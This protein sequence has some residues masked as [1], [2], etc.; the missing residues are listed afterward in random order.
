MT[1][2]R[3]RTKKKAPA[4]RKKKAARRSRRPPR[5]DP[6][7]QRM[8][9]AIE[10]WEAYTRLRSY[11]RVADELGVSVW[12]VQRVLNEDKGRLEELHQQQLEERVADF[13]AIGRRALTRLADTL[14]LLDGNIR[15][16]RAAAAEGRVTRV[17]D[18]D[19]R[20]LPV[21][22]ATELLV[23]TQQVRQLTD[24]AVKAH[25][26]AASFRAG[27]DAEGRQVGATAIGTLNF[28]VASEDEILK[29]L[30]KHPEVQLPKTLAAKI[31]RIRAERGE[32]PA[33]GSTDAAGN[34]AGLG[35]KSKRAGG[36]RGK[37]GADSSGTE[38]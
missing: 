16:V 6:E 8:Q 14:E 35:R 10:V 37:G 12:L 17:L 20:A 38:G 4:K 21:Y 26:V 23:Q 33:D 13:E 7:A 27:L 28:A 22:S 30:A 18:K 9:R 15:E 19:G 5:P 1:E 34:P 32:A 29:E 3:K 31:E 24:L 2:R 11:R 25:T 36:R